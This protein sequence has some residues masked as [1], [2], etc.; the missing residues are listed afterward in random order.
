MSSASPQE[1]QPAQ[2]KRSFWDICEEFVKNLPP[3]VIES[4]PEDGADQH[5][6]YIYGWPKKTIQ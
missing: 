6:H 5:D 2:Q 4:L 1:H 3:E